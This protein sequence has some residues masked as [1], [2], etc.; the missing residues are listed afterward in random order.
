MIIFLIVVAVV[1]Y[2]I[3]GGC[4]GGAALTL[5]KRDCDGCHSRYGTCWTPHGTVAFLVGLFWPVALPVFAGTNAS[6]LITD[7]RD[8]AEKKAASLKQKHDQKMAEL[9]AVNEQKRLEL[10]KM[11][12]D[13]EFLEA[14]GVRADVPGLEQAVAG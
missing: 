14:N 1:A 6:V 7:R 5:Q 4:V 12:L 2:L 3:V 9:S 13:I 10:A 11:K 8:R